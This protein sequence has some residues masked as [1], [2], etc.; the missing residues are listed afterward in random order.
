LNST[1]DI[2]IKVKC[3]PKYRVLYELPASTNVVIAIGGRGGG[4]TYELSKWA[5]FQA[6]IKKKRCAILRDEKSLIRESILNE[7]LLRY[8]TANRYGV[9]DTQYHKLDTGIKDKKTGEMLVFT[10]GFRASDNSKQANLKSISNVDYAIIEEGE[11]ITS[12]EKYNTFVDSIRNEGSIVVILLNTPHAGHFLLRR[13][14]NLTPLPH[15]DGYFSISPKGIPGVVV[16]QAGYEDNP[17][18]PPHVIAN[19]KGYGDPLHHLYNMHYYLTA[20][21]GYSSTGRKG[22]IH[23]KIKPISLADYMSLPYPERYGQDFGTAAPAALVGVKSYKNTVWCR[24]ISYVPMPVLEIAKMYCRLRFGPSDRIVADQADA[25]AIEKL[26]KGFTK[27]EL[28]DNEWQQ[29]PQLLRGFYV[30]PCIKGKDSV[31]FGIDLMDGLDMYA[32]EESTNLW[33]EITNRVWEVDKNGNFTDDPEPGYDHAIDGIAYV[34][35]DIYGAMRNS[36][37]KSIGGYLK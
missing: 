34:C 26:K 36:Q 5:A 12:E 21:M 17:Y 33:N 1:P 9:L 37:L 6:T 20:I 10:K 30:V 8:D 22:Q 32:V 18:L 23:R 27:E 13:Y 25:K 19:Y 7:V 24:E 28:P 14:F 35:V 11:D 3:L 16:I 29:Y 2:K 4:K 15:H 31:K